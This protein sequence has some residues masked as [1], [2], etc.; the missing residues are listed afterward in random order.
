MGDMP[1]Q[2]FTMNSSDWKNVL[3]SG[4]KFLIPLGVIYFGAI[5]A[6]LQTPGHIFGAKDLQVSNLQLGAMVLYITNRLYD[7]CLK[8]VA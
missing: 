7:I 4:I 3:K 2:K 8:F 1:S 5:V 6:S